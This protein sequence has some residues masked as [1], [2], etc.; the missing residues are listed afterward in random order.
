MHV[1]FL[2]ISQFY[3]FLF[4]LGASPPK[5]VQD[6][7]GQGLCHACLHCAQGLEPHEYLLT[8]STDT[9]TL[10]SLSGVGAI[11]VKEILSLSSQP[12]EQGAC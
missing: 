8:E 4:A 11:L 9:K 2:V 12:R 10:G 7:Q 3:T 1:S 5:T 6:T